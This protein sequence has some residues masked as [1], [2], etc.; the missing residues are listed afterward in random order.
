MRT[1]L[2]EFDFAQPFAF[3]GATQNAL[4]MAGKVID[5]AFQ[6]INSSDMVPTGRVLA[7]MMLNRSFETHV[8]QL[9]MTAFAHASYYSSMSYFDGKSGSFKVC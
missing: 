4:E 2:T 9:N 3:M 8:G 1:L 7:N 5:E 6:L